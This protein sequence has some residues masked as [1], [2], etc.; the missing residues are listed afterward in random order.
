MVGVTHA[1]IRSTCVFVGGALGILPFFRGPARAVGVGR[2]G[3][4]LPWLC[5]ST[6]VPRAAD[7]LSQPNLYKADD[8]FFIGEGGYFCITIPYLLATSSGSP[9]AFAEAFVHAATSQV[10]TWP[11]SA[12]W[13]MGRP[14][15]KAHVSNVIGN[16]TPIQ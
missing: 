12:R 10:P 4:Y 13:T 1:P 9:I 7:A 5:L 2:R 16:A 14:S 15:L 8:V 11:S 6:R 3:A